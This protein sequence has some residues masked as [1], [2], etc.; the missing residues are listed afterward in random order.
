M[1]PPFSK[2]KFIIIIISVLEIVINSSCTTIITYPT[3]PLLQ[4]SPDITLTVN[5]KPVWVERVAS[6]LDTFDYTIGLYGGRKMEDMDVAS[7]AFT[8]KIKIRITAQDKI[9]SYIIRPKSRNIKADVSGN[10]ISFTIDSPQKLY[11]EINDQPHLAVFADPPEDN[12]PPEDA[13]GLTYFGPG[14]HNQGKIE[15]KNNQKIYIAAGA[16][17]YADIA[18]KDLHDV[19][20]SGRGMIQGKVRVNNTSNLHVS[21]VF[22]RNTK[23]WTNT[24]TNCSNSS[25]RNVKVFGYEAIYSVDGINPVSCKNFTIDNCFMRCRDDCVAI[26]SGNY[27]LSVDSI[28]VTNC[29]MVG[30]SCS[31]GVTIGFELNGGPVQNILVKNCDILYARGGGRTGGHAPFS[32]V[33]DGP[34]LVQNIR[35]EDIR[36]EEHVEFKSLEMIVT[37]GTLYG[38]DPPG[39][40]KNV[41]MKNIVWENQ[42]KPFIFSGFSAEN[43]IENVVFDNCRI[44][45]KMLTG[46]SDAEFRINQFAEN[47]IFIR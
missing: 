27:E 15:L 3:P 23:G 12:P 44:G 26:K 40:I 11:I 38:E 13:P 29:V 45:D 9:E 10:E 8:G 36:I 28:M 47:I 5:N 19:T 6:K 31:D 34:A 35:Y 2:A 7:F 41:Y 1:K 33:C 37:D 24:L 22:I 43:K 17:V 30:W 14:V 32:I 20:I 16:I 39:H 18:G 46:F 21:D 42:D 25:Y 4:T